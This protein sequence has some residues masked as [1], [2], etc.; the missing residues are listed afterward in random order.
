VPIL[1]VMSV[2]QNLRTPYIQSMTLN[3]QQGVWAGGVVQAGFVGTLGRK[4]IYT[5]DVNAA[6]PGSGAV[7]ARRPYAVQYPTLG[8]INQLESA[9]ISDYGALQLQYTQRMV[10]GLTANVAYTFG[11]A[12]DTASEPRNLLPADSFHAGLDRGPADFDAR[13]ILDAFVSYSLP[14]VTSHWKWLTA[15]WQVNTLITA[16]SGLPV[17]FRAGTDSNSDGDTFDRIDII[18]DPFAAVPAAPNATSR[19][20]I[21]RDAFRAAAPGTVG[22]LG[23]NAIVGQ[24]FFTVDP[25]MFKEFPIRERFRAQFRVEVFNA[26]SQANYANPTVQFNSGS[27]GLITNTRNG[28]GAPGLGFGEPR[29]VQLVLKVLW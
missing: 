20:W 28:G 4:L 1:G 23:R 9:A 22:N 12:I 21:N 24:G 8:A 19:R 3:V 25:S 17:T 26:L 14:T 16:H 10:K 27:F 6:L 15:G 7:R 18:G 5:R 29:N 11:K 2:N 13:H